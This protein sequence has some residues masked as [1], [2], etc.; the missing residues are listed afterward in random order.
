[1]ATAPTVIMDLSPIVRTDG[2]NDWRLVELVVKA[3]QKSEPEAVFFGVADRSLFRQM[4]EA[5]KQSLRRWQRTGRALV[6]P[7]ADPDILRLATENPT[8]AVLTRDLYRDMRKEYPWLQNSDR[9][10]SPVFT[11]D[12]VR[13]RRNDMTAI[14]DHEVSR[15]VEASDL[16]PLGINSPEA[17]QA[18]LAEWACDTLTCLWG[19]SAV[20]ETDPAFRDG[21]VRC[22]V[23]RQPARRVGDRGRTCEIVLSVGGMEVERIPLVEGARIVFGRGRGEDRYDVRELLDD[24]TA[25]LVSRDHLALLNVGGKVRA[26]ELGSKNGSALIR[27]AQAPA[28]LALG[29]QQVLLPGQRVSLAEGA[30]ELRPSGKQRP[31]GRYARDLSSPP[32]WAGK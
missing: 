10:Y 26:E 20:I 29:I 11:R 7:W 14:A 27:E 17:R 13:F 2:Y 22:P 25:T 19:Q 32:P 16:K 24:D 30:V 9:L 31:H 12:E 28:P 15:F 8:A 3:W 23:C 21:H 4:D 5:G 6:V 18:L 1:M